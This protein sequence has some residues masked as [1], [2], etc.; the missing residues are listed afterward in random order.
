[1]VNRLS[2]RDGKNLGFGEECSVFR[3]FKRCLKVL[4]SW[5][6]VQVLVKVDGIQMN[7]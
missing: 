6:G 7:E 3:I 4:K 2:L 1:M 5:G